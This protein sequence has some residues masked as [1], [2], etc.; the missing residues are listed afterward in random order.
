MVVETKDGKTFVVENKSADEYRLKQLTG[1]WVPAG[2]LCCRLGV[3]NPLGFGASAELTELR[4]I[5]L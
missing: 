4:I 2:Q 3:A 1:C 5:E